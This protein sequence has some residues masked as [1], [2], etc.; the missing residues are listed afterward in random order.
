MEV[1]WAKYEESENFTTVN[2]FSKITDIGSKGTDFISFVSVLLS[3]GNN[4]FAYAAVLY[5]CFR[6]FLISS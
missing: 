2:R 5:I 4:K 6:G 3:N 1:I